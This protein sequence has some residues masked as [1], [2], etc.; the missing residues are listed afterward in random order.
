MVN[1]GRFISETS[2][3]AAN[4]LNKKALP[5][6]MLHFSWTSLQVN[7]NTLADWHTDQYIIGVSAMLALGDF[8]GGE[9][10]LSGHAPLE[11][12]DH[13]VFFDGHPTHCSLPFEGQRLTVVA[14]THPLVGDVPFPMAR[15][16]RGLGFAL[17]SR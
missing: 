2:I 5:G 16:L 7:V 17:R 9:F 10:V 13:L 1:D 15:Q 3:S 14:F 6:K 12:K 4:L 8:S 11:L